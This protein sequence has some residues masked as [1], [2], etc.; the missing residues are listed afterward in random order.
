MLKFSICIPTHKLTERTIR[1]I[2]ALGQLD[3]PRN[4]FEV[5]IY[6]QGNGDPTPIKDLVDRLEISPELVGVPL[7][8]NAALNLATAPWTILLD[9]DDFLVPSSLHQLAS[10]IEK[11]PITVGFEFSAINVG[12]LGK[13]T[14]PPNSFEYQKYYLSL[15]H[16]NLGRLQ[17]TPGFGRPILFKT[18]LGLEFDPEVKFLEER[19]LY[20]DAWAKGIPI[21]MLPTLSYV[22]NW[23]TE[24]TSYGVPIDQDARLKRLKAE[25]QALYGGSVSPPLIQWESDVRAFKPLT[26]QDVDFI[27]AVTHF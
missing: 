24:A 25:F 6:L 2:R 9:H 19:K 27:E 15:I 5:C 20:I 4:E 23:N 7:A 12:L 18:G 17:K 1:T 8:K 11:T 10:V 22:Y 21:Q 3:Y 26:K 16:E 14:Y 13:T